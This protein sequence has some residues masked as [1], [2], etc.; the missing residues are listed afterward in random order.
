MAEYI[1]DGGKTSTGIELNK[2]DSMYVYGGGVAN[3]VTA[4]NTGWVEVSSGG[5]ANDVTI[6][7]GG[8][9][10]LRNSGTVNGLKLKPDGTLK[11]SSG[12]RLTGK[13]DFGGVV[14]AYQGAILDFDLT[15]TA[16]L[17]AALVNDF[18]Y[19]TGLPFT[20]TLTVD[21]S[22]ANG[23]YYLADDAWDFADTLSVVNT[24]GEALGTLT[25]DGEAVYKSGKMYTLS[26]DASYLT[27]TVGDLPAN[28][29]TGDL[30]NATKNIYAGSSALDVNVN[31]M[32]R[33]HIH[34][35]AVAIDTTLK[36]L[37][38][39]YVSEGG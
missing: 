22:L 26:M 13:L 2:N 27:V 19:V 1:V 30:E 29:F 37:G 21:A 38:D 11:V 34:D 17:T 3:G 32:G 6:S 35:G 24:S 5:T 39:L 15:Q 14:T 16:P 9:V 7:S 4:K 36:Y 33:L 8:I 12:G 31:F 23:D 28:I 10:Y 25:V 20:Y 18:A